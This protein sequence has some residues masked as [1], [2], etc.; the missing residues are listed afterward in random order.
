MSLQLREACWSYEP[1]GVVLGPLTLS[2]ERAQIT[3][4][5]G[6]SG[7]GKSTAIS[8]L[9]GL[10]APT[11]G[12]VVCDG[13]PVAN[14]G[15]LVGHT[16]VLT[17]HPRAA[18]DPRMRIGRALEL[19]AKIGKHP[20]DVS[21]LLAEVGLDSGVASRL[22]GELSGG[23]LA[24]AML[25]RAL[26]QQPSYLLAD[27]A[28]GHMDP[29]TASRIA[30]VLKKRSESGLGVLLVTHDHALAAGLAD[31]IVELRTGMVRG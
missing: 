28:T 6:E 15:R 30:Q 5:V 9:A 8:L 20:V 23:Q 17:Q 18:A 27:E 7:S 11:S 3:A 22:P 26:A 19:T 21:K 10:L 16:A 2:V 12:E 25:A 1:G 14:R 4:V 13:A 31:S 24:R 29:V